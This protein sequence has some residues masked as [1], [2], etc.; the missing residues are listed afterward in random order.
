[1]QMTGSHRWRRFEHW[2]LCPQAE[3][4]PN[5]TPLAGKAPNAPEGRPFEAEA[6]AADLPPDIKALLKLQAEREQ[7][8]DMQEGGRE[9][10]EPES[11]MIFGASD[12]PEDLQALPK[13]S[14]GNMRYAF[15]HAVGGTAPLPGHAVA[16]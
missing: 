4:G 11:S 9:E 16:C 8:G 2:I 3:G 15:P 14:M 6:E 13:V 10:L 5:E 1:M 12:S 7:L